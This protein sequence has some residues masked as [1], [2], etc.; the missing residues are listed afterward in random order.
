VRDAAS[1]PIFGHDCPGGVSQATQ[2][3][4]QER[5]ILAR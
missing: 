5:R 1:C 4:A 2:C 3:R